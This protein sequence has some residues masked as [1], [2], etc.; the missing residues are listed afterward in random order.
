MSICL[1]K[2]LKWSYF[3]PKLVGYHKTRFLSLY[4]VWFWNFKHQKWATS[5][6]NQQ[7]DLCAQRRLR[8]AR[9]SA[10]RS[11]GFLA[12]HKAYSKDSDQTGRMRR[13]IWVFAGH[14]SFCFIMRQLKY[15]KMLIIMIKENTS[16][17]KRKVR[18]LKIFH[19]GCS[20]CIRLSFLNIIMLRAA[21]PHIA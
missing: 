8:S 7:N 2:R 20:A 16:S 4:F 21:A 14:T 17:K 6:Q 5:W 9:A 3:L 10:W 18:M 11:I 13:L 1:H 15:V 19:Q 12:I